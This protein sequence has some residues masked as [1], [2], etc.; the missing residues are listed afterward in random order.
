MAVPPTSPKDVLRCALRAARKD[1]AK[2]R[3]FLTHAPH[4]EV[5]RTM[6]T[7]SRCVAGYWPMGG[8]A[9]VRP[10][11]SYAH[12]FNIP[13][14]LPRFAIGQPV[15]TFH[16]W[17]QADVLV[18]DSGY[19]MPEANAPRATPDLILTP[20]VGFDRALNRLGQGQGH[21]DRAFL[22]FPKA[23]KVGVA[24]SVQE[25]AAL[26]IELHDIRLDAVLTEREWIVA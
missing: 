17:A 1:F 25:C 21:Y 26:P 22:A 20:L 9:D 13:V 8:E 16:L 12:A 11:L 6:I 14:V 24:W 18:Q 19:A 4:T 10:L 7:Q 23:Y 5:L 2:G 3:D 15:M